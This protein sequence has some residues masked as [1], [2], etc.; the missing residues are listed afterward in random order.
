ME[1]PKTKPKFPNNLKK[2][3]EAAGLSQDALAEKAGTIKG[4]IYK[5]ESGERKLTLPWMVR[6]SKHLKCEPSDLVAKN[7]TIASAPPALRDSEIALVDAI[8]DLIQLLSL[9][10]PDAPSMLRSAFSYQRTEYEE[11]DLHG[12]AQVM[13]M[14]GKF[15]GEPASGTQ[16]TLIRRLLQIAPAGSA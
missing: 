6:L 11:G 15:V 14:L 10:H 1:K 5:L 7:I 3:R 8:K 2:L 4:Q 9:F 13:E 12:A 16:Q